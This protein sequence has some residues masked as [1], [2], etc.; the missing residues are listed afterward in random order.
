MLQCVCP[1]SGHIPLLRQSREHITILIPWPLLG[2]LFLLKP[3]PCRITWLF[4][5]YWI[6]RD[7]IRISLATASL[8]PSALLRAQP[9][10]G[11]F[12][13]PVTVLAAYR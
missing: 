10:T 13:S 1:V 8:A 7:P 5:T 4:F 2:L 9:L 12:H 6:E 11:K 3:R